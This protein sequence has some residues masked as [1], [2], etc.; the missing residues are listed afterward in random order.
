MRTSGHGAGDDALPGFET[1]FQDAV[2]AVR[3]KVLVDSRISSARLEAEQHAAHGLSWLATYV[4]ALRELKAYGERLEAEG[5]YGAVEDYALRI[6]AGAQTQGPRGGGGAPRAVH[7][8]ADHA[9]IN[10]DD[11]KG[12]RIVEGARAGE[13]R[14]AYRAAADGALR[15]EGE[16]RLLH[17]LAT[18]LGNVERIG[19]PRV[20]RKFCGRERSRILGPGRVVARA[21]H[22]HS[23]SRHRGA[24]S[25][26]EARGIQ[27]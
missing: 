3:Q 21:L 20:A 19:Q 11:G 4:T 2:A 22:L 26:E 10:R 24:G 7:A 12:E 1:L 18:A 25:H 8:T 5:R 14:S 15:D 27:S 23:R 13:H 9:S 6:G 17:R 16:L